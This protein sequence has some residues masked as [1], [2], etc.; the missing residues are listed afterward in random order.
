M[1]DTQPPSTERPL[2][3]AGEA[4]EAMRDTLIAFTQFTAND[5]RTIRRTADKTLSR[6]RPPT[7]L[8]EIA[9]QIKHAYADGYI[10]GAAQRSMP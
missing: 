6:V 2:V 8:E 9:E 10:A 1:T 5:K 3:F 4:I 7:P